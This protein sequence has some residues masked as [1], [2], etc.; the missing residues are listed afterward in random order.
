MSYN[1]YLRTV[2]YGSRIIEMNERDLRRSEKERQQR[3]RAEFKKIQ[4]FF[5][6]ASELTNG[7]EKLLQNKSSYLTVDQVLDVIRVIEDEYNIACK[8]ISKEARKQLRINIG[9]FKNDYINKFNYEIERRRHYG[10]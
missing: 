5:D 3:V 10:C 6:R 1:S 4:P 8:Y 2:Y 7:L 9:E